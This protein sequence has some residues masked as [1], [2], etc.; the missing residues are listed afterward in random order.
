MKKNTFLPTLPGFGQTMKEKVHAVSFLSIMFLVLLSF[1]MTSGICRA[2]EWSRKS[3]RE[4]FLTGQYMG[5]DTTTHLGVA[6]EFDSTTVGG[7]GVG[8]NLNDHLNLNSDLFIGS[9][10]FTAN[11]LGL[12]SKDSCTLVG[13]DV[14]LDLNML[15]TR[16]TPMVTVGF[17]FISFNGDHH[18]GNFKETNYSYNLG[19][20]FRWDVANHFLIKALYRAT[21]TE[22]EDAK[23]TILF[24][25]IS[26]S[27]GYIF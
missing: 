26:L 24:D 14:N 5:S 12:T 16:F 9:T 2:E 22:L 25:G 21:W 18:G 4:F 19:G 1:A 7:L 6:L 13:W 10:D 20:G 23:D 27:I 8:L 3:K 15:K 11:G 17:G